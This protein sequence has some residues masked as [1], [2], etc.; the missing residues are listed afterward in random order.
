MVRLPC[1]LVLYISSKADTNHTNHIVKHQY[2]K[3]VTIPE[4][5]ANVLVT[6]V[7]SAWNA[8]IAAGSNIAT[9]YINFHYRIALSHVDLWLAG[10]IWKYERPS[11][12][13]EY[14][15]ADAVIRDNVTVFI[16]T[17]ETTEGIRFSFSLPK[18]TASSWRPVGEPVYYWNMTG[19]EGCDTGCED[20]QE[21]EVMCV[22]VREDGGRRET[23]ESYCNAIE[24]P[25]V[26][27]ACPLCQYGWNSTE[28]SQCSARCGEGTVRREVHCA[29]VR[30]GE[31]MRVSERF[32]GGM[33][34]PVMVQSCVMEPCR[35]NWQVGEWGE[36]DVMCGEGW[37][38]RDVTCL[39]QLKD[40]E[41]EATVSDSHCSGSKPADS[42]SCQ[43]ESCEH[44]QW[45]A[46]EWTEVRVVTV[47]S[48]CSLIPRPCVLSLV[49][50]YRV[51]C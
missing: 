20:V 18:E 49:V 16:L 50:R 12:S 47:T 43:A 26:T 5:A 13:P 11:G 23:N 38:K 1:N 41:L 9:E 3:A 24:K 28:W 44:F 6:E 25:L 34:K 7:R 36:C 19:W 42:V 29:A 32:C 31:T 48:V 10:T 27:R 4:G 15:R 14:L 22:E 37:M 40:G 30:E 51:C 17:N 45:V 8:Y 39:L 46:S 35:Y 2:Y 21:R 33:T